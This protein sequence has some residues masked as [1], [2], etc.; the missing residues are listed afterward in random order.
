MCGECGKGE[1]EQRFSRSVC[2]WCGRIYDVDPRTTAFN[3]L[4]VGEIYHSGYDNN[5]WPKAWVKVD[6]R[7]SRTLDEP[8]R[9][10]SSGPLAPVIRSRDFPEK[11]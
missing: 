7:N 2:N 6:E 11:N 10:S 9:T 8:T 5:V 4:D 1:V 3:T